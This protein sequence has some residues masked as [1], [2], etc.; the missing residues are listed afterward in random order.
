MHAH[1]R[2]NGLST[3]G[4][5]SFHPENCSRI[6]M[7][8]EVTA[9]ICACVC[10]FECVCEKQSN[11]LPACQSECGGGGKSGIGIRTP[12]IPM[13]AAASSCRRIRWHGS[14]CAAA[15]A[16]NRT[17]AAPAA[18][19][20]QQMRRSSVVPAPQFH[21]TINAMRFGDVDVTKLH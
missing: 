5:C 13:P 20:A 17:S 2:C 15:P 11:L 1:F 12:H 6:M 16:A 10:V 7:Y 19:Q 4:L 14:E 3:L 18:W 8:D 9:N 21:Y